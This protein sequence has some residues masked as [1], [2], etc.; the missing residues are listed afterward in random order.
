M[1]IGD[2][3][4]AVKAERDALAL[5]YATANAGSAVGDLLAEAR[6]SEAQREKI[7]S[8]LEQALTD[9]FYT[10]LLALDGGAKLGTTQQSYR[11]MG[12]DGMPVSEG[13]G[14]LEAAA[15]DAFQSA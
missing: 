12:E 1:Q 15:F 14:S 10:M 11:L 5:S 7:L 4:N 8:A 3:V 9:A 13:D 6:L 2:F